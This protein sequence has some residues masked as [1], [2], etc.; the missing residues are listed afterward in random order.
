MDTLLLVRGRSDR[1]SYFRKFNLLNKIVRFL[2]FIFTLGKAE[3]KIQTEDPAVI[4]ETHI[5]SR[6]YNPSK[7]LKLRHSENQLQHEDIR[8][9]DPWSVIERV[10]VLLIKKFLNISQ[11]RVVLEWRGPPR[12]VYVEEVFAHL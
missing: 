8:R 4:P 6:T 5:V 2:K 3:E 12:A 11:W 9:K 10:N 7:E 1:R